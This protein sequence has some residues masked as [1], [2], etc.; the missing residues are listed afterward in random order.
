MRLVNAMGLAL[1]MGP[2]KGP[3]EE[4]LPPSPPGRK[5]IV[6]ALPRRTCA[7]FM[8]SESAAVREWSSWFISSRSLCWLAE[9][10]PCSRPTSAF[11]SATCAVSSC[12]SPP[13][14]A[15]VAAATAA[16]AA[17]DAAAAAVASAAAASACPLSLFS[18]ERGLYGAP[19][20]L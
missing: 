18:A 6:A 15:A 19:D 17:A 12:A 10:S 9:S 14:A 1:A 16:A 4:L 3:A 7:A 2:A 20:R 13:R 8:P 11:S 5:N